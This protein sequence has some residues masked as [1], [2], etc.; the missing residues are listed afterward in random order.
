MLLILPCCELSGALSCSLQ[1]SLCVCELMYLICVG[2]C[3]WLFFV[4]RCSL[5]VVSDLVVNLV[6]FV[7]FCRCLV[8]WLF[9]A[10]C[11]PC[12]SELF[13]VRWPLS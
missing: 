10:F 13:L 3:S 8:V 7:V 6:L 4:F 2:S 5:F 9:A 11:V 1:L 12:C